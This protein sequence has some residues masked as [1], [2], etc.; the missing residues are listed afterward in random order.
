MSQENGNDRT[1]ANRL[2]PLFFFI[3]A[4]TAVFFGFLGYQLSR[5]FAFISLI[6]ETKVRTIGLRYAFFEIIGLILGLLLGAFGL[7]LGCLIASRILPERP[8]NASPD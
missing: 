6:G 3:A 2:T 4:G 1:A 5:L 8:A 7:S